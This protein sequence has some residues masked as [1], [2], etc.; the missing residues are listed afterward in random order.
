MVCF[1]LVIFG[2]MFFIDMEMGFKNVVLIIV[3]YGLG[4]N[5]V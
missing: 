5:V 3:V 1:D 2:V 4:E